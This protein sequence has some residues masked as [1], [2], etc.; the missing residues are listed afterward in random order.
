M[1]EWKTATDS[2][3]RPEHMEDPDAW[4]GRLAERVAKAAAQ[5]MRERPG[6]C[7]A[8]T[9]KREVHDA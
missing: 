1:G 6:E 2:R 8:L 4:I 5:A 7:V 9:F 3:V